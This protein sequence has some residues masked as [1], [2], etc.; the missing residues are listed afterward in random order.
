ME[1]DEYE[2][3]TEDGEWCASSS[4]YDDAKHYALVYLQ[5]GKPV[6]LVWVRRRV[7]ERFEIGPDRKA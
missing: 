1:N 2:I 5:D 4:R 6:N 7:V 3:Y